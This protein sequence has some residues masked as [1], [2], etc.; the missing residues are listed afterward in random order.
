[1]IMARFCRNCGS[2]VMQ[3]EKFCRNCGFALSSASSQIPVRQGTDIETRQTKDVTDGKMK[4]PVKKP[5]RN[6]S[7]AKYCPYCR[8]AVTDGAKFC[9]TCGHSLA[10]TDPDRKPQ[11]T[12][13]QQPKQTAPLMAGAGKE[14]RRMQTAMMPQVKSMAAAASAGE[15]D[16]GNLAIPGPSDVSDAVT[17]VL[18]PVSGIF[19][20]ISSFCGGIF[21]IFRKPSALIGAAALAVLWIILA[22]FRGSD[23]EVVK[24]LSWLTFSEGGLD[25]SV[26]GT[27]GGVLGKGT[28]AAALVSLFSGRLKDVFK[29]IGSLF[30]GHG[31]K[32]GIFSIVFGILIGGAVYIAFAGADNASGAT[33]MPGI[34]GIILSLEALGGSSGKLYELAQNLTSRAVNGVRTAA[35]GKCEGLLTGLTIGF[36]LAT[37]LSALL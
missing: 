33:A 28:V 37:V 2:A 1:M 11:R 29:G 21:A 22:Q 24:F 34:A 5:Q 23:S 12:S 20:G 16:V 32:R 35:K 27:V 25:R 30:T 6:E 13:V 3:D 17:T 31:E 8:S 7:A 4:E 26:P 9:R 10:A 18:S 14:A 15:F 36:A 19:H